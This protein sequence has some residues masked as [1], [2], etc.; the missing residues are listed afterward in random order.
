M[1]GSG[2]PT[3]KTLEKIK[4]FKKK[5]K[6]NSTGLC[7]TRK[8][9]SALNFKKHCSHVYR[10][11]LQPA[12]KPFYGLPTDVFSFCTLFFPITFLFFFHTS[13]CL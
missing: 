1:Q 12:Q 6:N 9:K 11:Y 3:I 13:D 7:T 10:Q 2:L 4:E 5:T 8:T